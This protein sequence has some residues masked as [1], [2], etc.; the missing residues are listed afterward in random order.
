[1]SLRTVLPSSVFSLVAGP[2][3][4][5][6]GFILKKLAELDEKNGPFSAAFLM[7]GVP[8]VEADLTALFDLIK[9]EFTSKTQ[10]KSFFV[11]FYRQISNLFRG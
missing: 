6:L 1:M 4:G 10:K 3:E 7:G 2:P 8:T 11:I 9:T 5:E